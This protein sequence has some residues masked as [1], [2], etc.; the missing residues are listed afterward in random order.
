MLGISA[1]STIQLAGTAAAR[2]A[3]APRRLAQV[4]RQL[5]VLFSVVFLVFAASFALRANVV[6]YWLCR[7]AWGVMCALLIS[8]NFRGL[9]DET[10][11]A[12]MTRLLATRFIAVP[13][14]VSLPEPAKAA[15][16]DTV[17]AADAAAAS[18]LPARMIDK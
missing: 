11:S 9:A 6:M 1:A 3:A 2:L 4:P 14:P 13:P 15:A 12:Y 17:L 16:K 10:I 8:P 7:A 5:V 18:K